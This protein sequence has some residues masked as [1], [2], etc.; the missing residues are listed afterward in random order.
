QADARDRAVPARGVLGE[1]HGDDRPGIL[2]NVLGPDRDL[3][4]DARRERPLEEPAVRDELVRARDERL[5]ARRP[6]NAQASRS[7]VPDLVG[8]LR[9][10]GDR[11]RD[12]RVARD[13][14]LVVGA[15]PRAGP[16]FTVRERLA[17]ALEVEARC[18]AVGRDPEVV[19]AP[20]DHVRADV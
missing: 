10:P 20:P 11:A 4:L 5:A 3:E 14:L 12:D 9:R 16:G 1:L 8:D 19:I 7:V 18:V 2:A 17:P 15:D 6:A 13:A